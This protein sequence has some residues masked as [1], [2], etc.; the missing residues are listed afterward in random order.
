MGDGRRP[1]FFSSLRCR[2]SCESGNGNC[3]VEEVKLI[4]K[5]DA[6][7][8]RRDGRFIRFCSHQRFMRLRLSTFVSFDFFFL[9]TAYVIHFFDSTCINRN[10][11]SYYLRIINTESPKS[12]CQ[13][14]FASI[15]PPLL[16]FLLL[17]FFFFSVFPSSFDRF[18]PRPFSDI[19]FQ[20]YFDGAFCDA[21]Y[22]TIY[23]LSNNEISS[24]RTVNYEHKTESNNF[25]EFQKN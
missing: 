8:W 17:F 6:G 16:F 21:P 24:Q 18:L 23:K 4:S 12:H 10:W 25:F 19:F 2:R 7:L 15:S 13:K 5:K 20:N 3:K 22:Y 14:I 11:C 1:L 9:I